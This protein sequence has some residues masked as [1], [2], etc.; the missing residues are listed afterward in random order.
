[1]AN[2]RIM[3][4]SWLFLYAAISALL[5]SHAICGSSYAQDMITPKHAYEFEPDCDVW[6]GMMRLDGVEF[7]HLDQH[8]NFN[9]AYQYKPDTGG[10]RPTANFINVPRHPKE[11]VYQFNDSILY[12]GILDDSFNFIKDDSSPPIKLIDYMTGKESIRIY[13]LPGVLIPANV[14]T[15]DF[16]PG[17][18]EIERRSLT[19]SVG[20]KFVYIPAGEFYMGSPDWDRHAPL[21]ERPQ[22][23]VKI[24]HDFYIGQTVVTQYQWKAI[25]ANNPSKYKG[26]DLPVENISWDDCQ[27]FIKK[28]SNKDR[29]M[30][31][32]P[33][34]AE[35]EYAC[36][37][38]T[39]SRF[40]FGR[41]IDT[42]QANYNGEQNIYSQKGENRKR[43]TQVN[44]FHANPWGLYDVHGN[45]NQWC[46]DNFGRS[47]YGNTPQENPMGPAICDEEAIPGTTRVVRGGAWYSNPQGCRSAARDYMR[48]KDRNSGT[49]FR[50]VLIP[51]A[52]E[53]RPE[54]E[55]HKPLNG[56]E[57]KS[58]TSEF[59]KETATVSTLLGTN[60]RDEDSKVNVITSAGSSQ[61]TNNDLGGG[62]WKY[63]LVLLAGLTVGVLFI[64]GFIRKRRLHNKTN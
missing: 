39:T 13:N 9:V 19:N 40:Y 1:M 3:T 46:S 54:I 18:D 26:D 45:I 32:L 21:D 38:G 61:K 55:I 30:Y 29:N 25:I 14:K 23:L 4:H 31:R 56:K 47:Y 15:S 58:P 24:T 6:V 59:N 12:K 5:F 20:I 50:V 42:D 64:L 7:G 34:E 27:E 63:G 36:R 16:Y 60:N 57:I 22:H 17:N 62:I 8:G 41:S 2:I 33:T 53:S 52:T 49:G 35:W 43:T 28:L 44:K 10:S 48:Q 51:S 37:A 11:Q